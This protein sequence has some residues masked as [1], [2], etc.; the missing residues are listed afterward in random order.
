MTVKYHPLGALKTVACCN[1]TVKLGKKLTPDRKTFPRNKKM[2]TAKS[3]KE[4]DY[5][6]L[7]LN[8]KVLDT[9]FISPTFAPLDVDYKKLFFA[10]KQTNTKAIWR[11]RRQTRLAGYWRQQ[12]KTLVNALWKGTNIDKE[13]DKTLFV[14]LATD[15]ETARVKSATA[16]H[17][18]MPVSPPRAHPTTSVPVPTSPPRAHPTTSVPVPTSPPRERVNTVV[19]TPSKRKRKAKNCDKNQGGSAARHGK[20]VSCGGKKNARCARVA[21]MLAM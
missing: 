19:R 20:E 3:R 17:F 13:D 16:R 14:N 1:N 2:E 10:L 15:D 21:R 7:A 9:V 6:K 4:I 18:T 12:H 8:K 11:L 5:K